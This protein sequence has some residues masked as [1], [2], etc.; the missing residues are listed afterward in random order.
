M[1][2]QNVNKRVGSVMSR[3]HQKGGFEEGEENNDTPI[4]EVL[5]AFTLTGLNRSD[6]FSPFFP[7]HRKIASRLINYLMSVDSVDK[8]LQVSSYGRNNINPNLFNYA[9]SVAVLNRTDTAD[10]LLLSPAE[11]FPDKFFPAEVFQHAIEELSVVP[12]GSRVE[13]FLFANLVIFLHIH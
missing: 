11:T 13:F 3:P 7:L 6:F 1:P 9:F 10:L 12:D 5:L 2:S 8:L 4:E